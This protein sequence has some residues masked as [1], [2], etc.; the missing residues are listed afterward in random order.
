MDLASLIT[1]A[2]TAAEATAAAAPAITGDVDHGLTTLGKG[3][4]FGLA[5]FGGAI[6]IGLVFFAAISGMAR[7]PEQAPALKT[8]AFLGFAFIEALALIGFVLT[9]IL[10]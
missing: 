10:K 5:A 6:G 3:L 7:Q 1:T 2:A 8:M 4:A 9:F